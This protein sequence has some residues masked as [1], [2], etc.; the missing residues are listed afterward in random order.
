MIT[1]VSVKMLPLQ[2]LKQVA[3][4]Q[5][6]KTWCFPTEVAVFN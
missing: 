1:F 2:Y 3:R 6:P 5:A 4:I